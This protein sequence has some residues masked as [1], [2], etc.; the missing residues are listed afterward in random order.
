MSSLSQDR[1]VA[2]GGEPLPS[3]GDASFQ[4]V[5]KKW[6]TSGCLWDVTLDVYGYYMRLLLRMDINLIYYYGYSWKRLN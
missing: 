5:G 6:R 3:V 2:I 1:V 4:E